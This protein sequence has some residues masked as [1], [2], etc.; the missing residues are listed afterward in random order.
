[1]QRDMTDLYLQSLK[2]PVSGRLEIQDARVN[3]LV[4]RVTPAG[5]ST[6]SVRH[7]LA[8]GKR[9]RPSLGRWPEMS[10]K[11]ARKRAKVVIGD[12]TRGKDPVAESVRRRPSA[13]RLPPDPR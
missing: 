4:L 9:V 8:D 10:I 2:P 13:P 3:G 1:M 12:I 7:R 6:W 11:E 5:V